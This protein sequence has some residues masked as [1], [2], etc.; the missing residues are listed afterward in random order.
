MS[1]HGPSF[2]IG[3]PPDYETARFYP[4]FSIFLSFA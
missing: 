4:S 3:Y 1:W 2:L